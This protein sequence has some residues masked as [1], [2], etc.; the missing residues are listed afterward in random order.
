MPRD[1]SATN[2]AEAAS[3]HIMPVV[4]ADLAFDSGTVRVHTGVGSLTF[5]SN[6]YSGVGDFGGIDVIE[7]NADL[8]PNAY[9]L[10][11]SGFDST[12]LDESLNQDVYGRA[13]TLYLG[14]LNI[15]GTLADDPEEVASG[16]MDSM[17]IT[18]GDQASINLVVESDLKFFQR[19]NGKLFTDEDQQIDYS[20]DLGFQ[21]LDQIQNARVVWGGKGRLTFGQPS[22]QFPGAPYLPVPRP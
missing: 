19:A 16:T 11:L 17:E 14:F 13:V 9:R 12:Y 1:L 7:E 10:R 15:D 5:N 21:Y 22:R 6:T 4:F 3:D 18:Y 8:T 2:L 20:G